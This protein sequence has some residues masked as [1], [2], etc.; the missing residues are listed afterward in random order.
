F[1]LHGLSESTG[2]DVFLLFFSQRVETY[3]VARY[4]DGQLRIFLRMFH[5]IEQHFTV[6]DVHVQVLT[7]FDGRFV[8]EVT[9]HQ[10]CQVG[11]THFIVF[12]QRVW[13]DGEGVRDTIF[14]VGKRQ[15]SNGGQRGNG[16]FLVATVHWVSTWAEWRASTTTIWGV[17]GFLTIHNVR[18]DGQ[19]RLSRDSV[20]IGSEFL[21]FL[22][23]T[24]YQVN[25]H[26]INASVV[27]TKLRIFAFDFEVDSQTIFVTNWFNFRIFDCRQGV[28]SN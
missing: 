10:A 16:T 3:C 7:T 18:G 19:N 23:E 20:T 8:V 6:H 9:I 25:R 1:P 5:R 4:T 11:L 21:N 15:F 13:H 22:H 28:S 27:V 2:N 12:T 17:T 24:F 14:R 26:V